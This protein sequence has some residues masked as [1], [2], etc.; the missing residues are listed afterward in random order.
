MSR[1]IIHSALISI[2]IANLQTIISIIALSRSLHLSLLANDLLHRSSLI[3]LVVVPHSILIPRSPLQ[4]PI[5]SQR[6]IQHPLKM[7]HTKRLSLVNRQRL[8]GTNRILNLP[9]IKRMLGQ[10]GE[11]LFR[12]RHSIDPF[13][14]AHT[15]DEQLENCFLGFWRELAVAEGDVDA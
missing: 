13:K 1:T 14:K 12:K 7:H 15:L 10:V 6:H 4:I 11:V 5:K 2:M 3:H 8:C 9:T